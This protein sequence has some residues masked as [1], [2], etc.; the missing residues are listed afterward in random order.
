MDKRDRIPSCVSIT[1]LANIH[2]P[3][4][5]LLLRKYIDS[6]ILMPTKST[7]IQLAALNAQRE[8]ESFIQRSHSFE[9][10]SLSSVF[11]FLVD[12]HNLVFSPRHIR[13]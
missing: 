3:V 1:C 11:P 2:P 4:N 7:F 5:D 9:L 12:S 6:N 10:S 13:M 8:T